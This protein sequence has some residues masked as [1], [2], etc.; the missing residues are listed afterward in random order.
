M[1][2]P[3]EIF[4]LCIWISNWI[5][6]RPAIIL[7]PPNFL[8]MLFKSM[9]ALFLEKNF[10]KFSNFSKFKKFLIICET[11]L[12]EKRHLE[13][14]IS[15]DTHLHQICHLYW[16]RTAFRARPEITAEAQINV[17]SIHL[18]TSFSF[19]LHLECFL[20][21]NF[22]TISI[23]YSIWFIRVFIF[24]NCGWKF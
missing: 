1:W 17:R 14:M 11:N 16:F 2:K 4:L 15:I 9:K 22:F 20:L 3:S 19:C 21:E 24:N 18:L 8:K 7:N 13:K 6:T 10:M 23:I 5:G 12:V